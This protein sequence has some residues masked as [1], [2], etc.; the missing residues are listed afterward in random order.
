MPSSPSSRAVR[1]G[2]SGSSLTCGMSGMWN[3]CETDFGNTSGWE[4]QRGVTELGW[5]EC[6]GLKKGYQGA[7]HPTKK[8]VFPTA[9][10]ILEEWKVECFELTMT[11]SV[12]YN[13]S[14]AR[15]DQRLCA[16]DPAH[17]EGRKHAQITSVKIGACDH[18]QWH[19]VLLTTGYLV[20]IVHQAVLSIPSGRPDN[21]TGILSIS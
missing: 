19:R 5:F 12:D 4:M 17:R 20:R 2:R 11:V 8:I 1:G 15:T 9:Q 16:M 21:R 14:R 18:T 10:D 7:N 3:D 6:G 13:M